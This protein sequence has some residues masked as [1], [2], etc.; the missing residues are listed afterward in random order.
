MATILAIETS[1][2]ACSVALSIDSEVLYRCANKP[3]SHTQLVMP[4]VQ[5]VLAEA[6]VKPAQ[7]DTIGVSIGPGSFTGLRI[8]FAVTQGLAYGADIPVVGVSSLHIMAQT[9]LR[10]YSNSEVSSQSLRILSLLDARMNQYNCGSYTWDSSVGVNLQKPD[11]LLDETEL[12]RLLEQFNPDVI[13][14]DVE[15][16]FSPSSIYHS[17]F[18]LLRPDARDLLDIARVD[19]AV[20]GAL[21]I[22]KLELVYLRGEEAWQQRKPLREVSHAD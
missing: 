1:T 2:D 9:Y 16:L 14:G 3:R 19:F 6:G 7:L 18:C 11:C 21:P 8:G 4:M 15:A 13:V 5:E 12:N 22:D 17:R 10:K 20:G